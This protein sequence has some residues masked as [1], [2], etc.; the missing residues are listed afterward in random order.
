MRRKG[1]E[2]KKWDSRKTFLSQ[3]LIFQNKSLTKEAR[4]REKTTDD[5]KIP[6][7]RESWFERL[8]PLLLFHGSNVWN[9]SSFEE[10]SS[11]NVSLPIL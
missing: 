1:K 9:L 8:E 3:Q 5:E 7:P 11:H 6:D 2:K 10:K 4:K